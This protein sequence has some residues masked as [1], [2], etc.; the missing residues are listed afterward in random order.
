MKKKDIVQQA[1]LQEGYDLI[2]VE[3][4]AKIKTISK[5]LGKNYK[6]ASTL[7]HVKDLPEKKLGVE[8]EG[9][10][11]KKTLAIEYVPLKGKKTLISEICKIAKNSNSVFLASDPDREGEIISY[12][13]GQEIE[14]IKDKSSIYRIVF[15]EITKPAIQSAINQKSQIDIKKV[16]AQQA[17][18]ILDRWVGYQVSPIL[19]KKISKGLS[20]GRVQSVA[21]LLICTR[22]EEIVKFKPEE[23]WSINAIFNKD[24]KSFEST[25]YKISN[26]VVKIKNESEA[27]KIESEVK[28]HSFCI[29]KITDK[30][31]L[32]KPL[33]P[34]MTSTLQQ[35]AYNKLG[36]SVDRTMRAAQKL[37][38]GI[39]LQDSSSPQA[40]ITYMRTD[41]L[42]LSD[43][44]LSQAR[45]FVENNFGKKYLPG[46]ANIYGKT[47]AQD[48]HE[49]IRPIS[50]ELT[51]E[52]IKS[53]L[54]PDFY[55][56]YDLIWKR[57]VSS[58]MTPA[59][60]AQRQILISQDKFTFKSNGSTLIFDGFLKVY[61]PA[62]DEDKELK[63]PQ[64]LNE[65]DCLKLEKLDKKQHFTQPP[66]RYTEASLV[67]E[68]EKLGI[69]RPSTYATILSTI[70]KR[71]YV[72]KDKKKFSPTELGK[73]VVKMLVE[74]LDD[75]IN[76]SFTAEMEKDLDSIAAGEK[77]R[78][79]VLFNFYEKFEKDLEKF[80]QNIKGKGKSTME[81]KIK[82]LTCKKENLVVRFGRTGEFLGCPS[83][84][85]CKFTAQMEKDENGEIQIAKKEEPVELEDKC[86]KCS[87]NLVR[88]KG[89][90]GYFAA[91]PGF[92]NCKHIQKI[93]A[94]KSE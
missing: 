9:Q 68:M 38:E 18:R 47:G 46:K 49:A 48:A 52:S 3:S 62:E 39:P 40:L 21:T 58:Q 36:F 19:W 26:K 7:G 45:S 1:P 2:I 54:E 8:I 70:Q 73:A 78:D 76:V 79:Q 66:P 5:F 33:P 84:P 35:D 63:L 4:P 30:E 20:A 6:L 59:K 91:C 93:S 14:K 56:L 57:T 29:E 23:S 81:T 87:K 16:E 86:P 77:Q 53:F 41:S 42:R 69:G 90:F 34:F 43:T 67:K 75:I 51:P 80:A 50:M 88:K 31:R 37:Y 65:K 55:K 32:K 83:Y 11:S 94:D 61:K 64:D 12:H 72:E 92:P 22:E 17:R 10:G 24:K 25:L 15:N 60:Y 27:V 85:D 89:K 13:I 74:N 82:C 28:K 71:N 44:A